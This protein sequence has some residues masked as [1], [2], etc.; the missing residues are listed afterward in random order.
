MLH[1]LCIKADSQ[2]ILDPAKPFSVPFSVMTNG[3]GGNVTIRANNNRRFKS[4]FPTSLMLE[5]GMSANGTVTISAPITTPS[6]T[7]VTLTIE[8]DDT[9][10][11]NYIALRF[12]VI[13]SVILPLKSHIC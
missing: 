10:D 11:T 6:G 5:T 9:E 1:S 2:S 7:D 3:K 13:N 4:T 12:S 8:V